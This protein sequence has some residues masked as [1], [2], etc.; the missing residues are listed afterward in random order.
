MTFYPLELE[1]VIVWRFDL[2]KIALSN[3]SR[4]LHVRDLDTLKVFLFLY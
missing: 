1:S 4:R 2:K 3:R